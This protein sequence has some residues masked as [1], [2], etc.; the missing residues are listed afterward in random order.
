ML[1]M[2][3][4]VSSSAVAFVPAQA[5]DCVWL[6]WHLLQAS[7]RVSGSTVPLKLYHMQ[8]ILLSMGVSAPAAAGV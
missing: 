2:F 5:V 7:D 6:P 3:D 1:Q 4:Y 8:N